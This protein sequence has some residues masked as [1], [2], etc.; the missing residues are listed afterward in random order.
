MIQ[1]GI[2][3][4]FT[5]VVTIPYILGQMSSDA[6]FICITICACLQIYLAEK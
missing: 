1:R 4:V 5:V 2:L 3:F 6:L